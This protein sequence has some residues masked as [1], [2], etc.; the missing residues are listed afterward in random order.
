MSLIM[1][2]CSLC[3]KSVAWDSIDYKDMPV[4]LIETTGGNKL[5]NGE[6]QW[7]PQEHINKESK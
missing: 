2:T 7:I 1:M 3:N 5:C 6:K 4:H